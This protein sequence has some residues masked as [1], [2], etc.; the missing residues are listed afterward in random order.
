MNVL[1]FF[2]TCILIVLNVKDIFEY[3]CCLLI[4]YVNKVRDSWLRKLKKQKEKS[5]SKQIVFF[6]VTTLNRREFL[7][8]HIQLYSLLIDSHYFILFLYAR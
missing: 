4:T 8:A 5:K 6:C 1:F 7:N 3:I 2:F